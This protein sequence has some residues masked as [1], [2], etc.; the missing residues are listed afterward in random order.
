MRRV[1]N[2]SIPETGQPAL[3]CNSGYRLL[4]SDG[5]SIAWRPHA[6]TTDENEQPVGIDWPTAAPASD[7][8][9]YWRAAEPA[10]EYDPG[11]VWNNVLLPSPEEQAREILTFSAS[12]RGTAEEGL[13]MVSACLVAESDCSL[14]CI[15]GCR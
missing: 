14:A 8:R 5:M 12:L 4:I 7:R 15:S 13:A 11:R 3:I 9:P 10:D 1:S 6:T 2:E